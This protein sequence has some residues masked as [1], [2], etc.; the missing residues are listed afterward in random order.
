MTHLL[1]TIN[2]AEFTYKLPTECIAQYP[3][4]QRDA[5]K[6][7]CAYA[8]DQSI[9]HSSISELPKHLPQGSLM[10][11]NDTRVIHARLA[12]QKTTGGA[13]EVFVIDPV[14]GIAPA[15]ALQQQEKTQWHCLI[16][17]R[18]IREGSVLLGG[19]EHIRLE[20][21]ILSLVENKARIEFH[22]QPSSLNFAQVLE[23]LGSV[24][25]P[26]Y[27]KREAES[28]DEERYQTVYARHEGSVAAPTAGLHLTEDLLR[29]IDERSVQ[30]VQLTL[31]VGLGTFQPMQVQD[32]REHDMHRERI[33][34]GRQALTQLYNFYSNAHADEG[35]LVC[36]GTTSLRSMESLYWLGVKIV[37]GEIT[38]DTDLSQP[39]DVEQWDA[40]RL[41][42]VISQ[43]ISP[44]QSIGAL[45][46]L[47]DSQHIDSLSAFTKLMI[48]PGYEIRTCNVL[49][50]NFHQPNSTLLL[51]VAAFLQG[52]FWRKVYDAAL[53]NEYRFLS[54]GDSSLLFR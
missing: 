7:L 30:R 26:P 32:A 21:H 20:A 54:Y 14:E 42:G 12:M 6:L 4:Q 10:V 16:G 15:L 13:A 18:N 53:K 8:Q 46:H 44:Q 48:V 47:M 51:L 27:M 3:L 2:A 19:N 41:S 24:P 37:Q 52:D 17:G 39:L 49:M 33:I 9:I 43:A 25:L 5:A 45:L 50:T 35:K 29:R 23:L 38:L 40:Y 36:V 22:I 1:P 34:V 11:M 31:H 28:R